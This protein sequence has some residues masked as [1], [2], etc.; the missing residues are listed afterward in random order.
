MNFSPIDK[1]LYKKLDKIQSSLKL[2]DNI[3]R[4]DPV[5]LLNEGYPFHIA[6]VQLALNKRLAFENARYWQGSLAIHSL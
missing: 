2:R 4:S 1:A 6:A 5:E 3:A